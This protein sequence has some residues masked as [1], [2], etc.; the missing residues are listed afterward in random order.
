MTET[1]S[2]TPSAEVQSSS[3]V[4]PP[5][6]P[7]TAQVVTMTART[8][9]RIDKLV[10]IGPV[11]SML[12]DMLKEG[13]APEQAIDAKVLEAIAPKGWPGVID[14]I[15]EAM[16]NRLVD[17]GETQIA[18]E[19]TAKHAAEKWSDGPKFD[20]AAIVAAAEVEIAHFGIV[21]VKDEGEP[22]EQPAALNDYQ[23]DAA[24][25]P[26]D[27]GAH[28]IEGAAAALAGLGVIEGAT[29]ATPEPPVIDKKGAEVLAQTRLSAAVVEV[30][31]KEPVTESTPLTEADVAPI[32][33]HF[34]AMD[35]ATGDLSQ[36]H[37]LDETVRALGEKHG[38]EA[39]LL[40]VARAWRRRDGVGART[41]GPSVGIVRAFA[42]K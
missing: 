22:A 20:F 19:L 1:S 15:Q 2:P 33:Q 23:N 8:A 3:P 36:Q 27:A 29:T 42:G 6:E 31:G 35:E 24:V 10:D 38:Y 4:V 26:V 40:C 12:S 41:V 28:H 14:V 11:I 7:L 37:E 39:L 32:V 9:E 16:V 18:A 5:S 34:A 21:V 25:V 30:V 17:G 13:T